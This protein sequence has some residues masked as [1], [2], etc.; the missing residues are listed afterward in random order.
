MLCVVCGISQGGQNYTYVDI[1]NQLVDLERLAVLPE[2]GE[3]CSQFSSYDR[4]SRFD[5]NTGKYIDWQANDDWTGFVRKEGENYVLAEMDCPGIIR[6]IWTAKPGSGNVKVFLDG[7]VEPVIDMPFAHFFDGSQGPFTRSE[8]V[9]TTAMGQNCYIP[10]PYQKSCKI[11]ADKNWPYQILPEKKWGVFYHFTYTT[12]PKGTKL[13]TFKLNL[14]RKEQVALDNAN[15]LLTQC[16]TDPAGT[17]KGQIT[18]KKTITVK[19]NETVEFFSIQGPHAITSLNVV[20]GWK[21]QPDD[22][23]ILRKLSL[24]IYWDS[25]ILPAV[26][27]PLGDFFGTAPGVNKYKSLPMGMTEDSFY[28]FWYMPFEKGAKIQLTNEDDAAYTLTFEITHAPL[29]CSIKK[30]GRFHAKWHRDMWLPVE[31]ERRK[32]DWTMLKTQGR[33]RYCGVMLHVWNPRG[34]WWGEGDEK[35]YIDG[36][37]F[38]STF[39]TGS[40]DYFGYAWCIPSLFSNCYHS[41]THSNQ[42][43]NQPPDPHEGNRGHVSVNRWHI[44][45]NMPFQTSFEAT[46]E[47]YCSNQLPTLYAATAYWYQAAGQ[48]DSYPPIA[49]EQRTGYWK[50]L[51]PTN[52]N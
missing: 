25:D 12:Y 43:A 48:A 17:R 19:P 4:R 42:I 44:A 16:G 41:Q 10:I 51:Q 52:I 23:D 38:P 1:I 13:P 20:P 24:A 6:R 2:E 33:G 46:I 31:V 45:D 50:P 28:S 35:I 40:E 27:S 7:Q 37:T 36:E 26:W 22:Y 32:I 29:T 39:G 47:K 18:E 8:L 30:L 5:S 11:V 34:G 9:N 49:V 14:F 21:I 15:K 3:K